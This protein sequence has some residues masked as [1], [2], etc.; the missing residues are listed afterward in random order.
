MKDNKHVRQLKKELLKS[1]LFYL[2]GQSTGWDKSAPV[3][4]FRQH[5]IQLV[6]EI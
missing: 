2:I 6:N 5:A 4:E 3:A 1:I